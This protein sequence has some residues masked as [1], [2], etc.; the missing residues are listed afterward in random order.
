MAGAKITVWN[1]DAITAQ[2][3]IAAVRGLRKA[4][5]FARSEIIKAISVSARVGEGG[6]RF[7]KEGAG[8]PQ[9]FDHSKAGEPPRADTG[10]L[11]QSVFAR[12]DADSL[13]ATIGSTSL[14]SVF[15]EKGTAAHDIYPVNKKCLCFGGGLMAWDTGGRSYAGPTV[16]IRQ[17]TK[18]KKAG[19]SFLYATGGAVTNAATGSQSNWIFAS[20]VHHPG[21]QPR[22]F[23]ASTIM[24]IAPQITELIQSEIAGTLG[25]GG[26]TVQVSFTEV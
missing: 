2:M 9:L 12:V 20:H 22:P 16:E 3:R 14:V 17:R 11:R 8:A 26:A 24:A 25:W 7:P 21:T 13:V 4:A 15:M 18:G 19:T 6:A 5:S 23:I 1:G 10:K